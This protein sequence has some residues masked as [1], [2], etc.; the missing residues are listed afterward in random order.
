MTMYKWSVAVVKELSVSE[1]RKH[2][3]T[4]VDEVAASK[5]EVVITKRGK[6]VARLV[7]CRPE[8]R[9]KKHPLRGKKIWISPDFD[10]PMDELWEALK[11]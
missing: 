6:P 2:L 3:L 10:E 5:D 8:P 9:A 4:L 7:P 11:E 1:T